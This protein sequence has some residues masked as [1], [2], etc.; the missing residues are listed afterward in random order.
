MSVIFAIMEE[1]ILVKHKSR[2]KAAYDGR[3]NSIDGALTDSEIHSAIQPS[4]AR[5]LQDLPE[6]LRDQVTYVGWTATKIKTDDLVEYEGEDFR[7]VHVM[8]RPI[9][10]FYKYMLGRFEG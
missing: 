3:G 6:G 5:V 4:S 2:G 8:D 1:A 7:V 9:D 10:G